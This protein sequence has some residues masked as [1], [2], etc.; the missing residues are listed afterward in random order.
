MAQLISVPD[1][2]MG[3]ALEVTAGGKLYNVVVEDEVVGKKLLS[4]GKLKRRVTI[5]PLNKISS[6]R[7]KEDVIKRAKD[8]VSCESRIK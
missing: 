3:T 4:N 7:L 5:I 8:E 6:S 1:L 2:K